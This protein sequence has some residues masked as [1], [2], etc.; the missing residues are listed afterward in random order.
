MLIQDF[1]IQT[2]QS[3]PDREA[4]VCRNERL[5]YAEMYRRASRLAWFFKQQHIQPG[6]RV[7]LF[8]DNGPEAVVNLFGI[9]MAGGVVMP[10]NATT[11]TEKL[12]HL[13]HH[14]EAAA[15]V[16]PGRRLNVF[17][18]WPETLPFSGLVLATGKRMPPPDKAPVNNLASFDAVLADEALSTIAPPR[19]R[20]DMDLGLLMYTSGSTGTPKGVMLTH[21]NIRTACLSIAQYLENTQDDIIQSVL[22]LSFGYGLTQVFTAFHCGAK[23]VLEKSLL[24]PHEVLE[25]MRREKVT[26]FPMVPTIGSILLKMDLTQYD[27]SSLRYMTNAG[28]ALPP[29]HAREIQKQLPHVRLYPMYGQ[30]ECI[31]VCY[32]S[33]EE[34]GKRPTSV[35]RPIPNVEV[36]IE[37][38]KGKRAAP[39]EP[40]IL[41]IRGSNVMAGYWK[42][43]DRTEEALRPGLLPQE[44][45]LRSGDL[46][47]MD[48]AG[49]LYFLSR[50]DDI[51]KSRGEKV[52][53][54]EVED[55]LYDLAGVAE[56]AVIGPTDPM[57]GQ[58]VVACLV[59]NEGSTLTEKEVLR[60]CSRQLEDFMVPQEVRI[61]AELPKTTTGKIDKKTLQKEV[62]AAS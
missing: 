6:D 40:G 17:C 23:L 32:L 5:T 55:V 54:K 9:L 8:L 59:V 42:M 2:A 35:G 58:R 24:Y 38:E 53:P 11:P 56:A 16:M 14:A 51:I 60:H 41:M 4:L 44:R 45:V 31:R 50:Q 22:P 61:M 20:I 52:S 48:S 36:W 1:L 43:P 18:E 46:F 3:Q 27:L 7:A 21:R 15:L 12:A 62:E 49:Y 30:T 19:N 47:R 25:R 33:P 37:N 26:G 13:L 57:L 34:V 10:V 28:A 39:D 29:R